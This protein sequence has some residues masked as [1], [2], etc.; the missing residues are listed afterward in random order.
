LV[1]VGEWAQWRGWVRVLQG[2]DQILGCSCGGVGGRG[3]RHSDAS[4][5]PFQG[6]GDALTAGLLDPHFVAAAVLGGWS[7]IETKHCV[8][9]PSTTFIWELVDEDT[10]AGGPRGVRLKSKGPWSWAWAES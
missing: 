8:R 6:V 10:S 4:G 2:M 1:L 9:G 5:K 7:S 3:A